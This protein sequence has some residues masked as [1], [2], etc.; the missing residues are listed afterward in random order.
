M[1]ALI[2]LL[3]LIFS[4]KILG[5]AAERIG[6][7]SIMG[8]ILAG[9]LLGLF[10]LHVETEI[11]SFFAELGSIFLLFTAGYKE[12]SL[13]DLKSEPATAFVPTFFQIAFAF[14]FGFAFG[15]IF[16]FNFLESF[17]MGVTFCPTAI[18]LVIR[19]LIDLNYLS[20]KPGMSILSSAVLDDIIGLFFLSI[21]ITFA[22][23][24]Y[25]PSFLTI[26]QIAGKILFFLLIMYILGK[27]FFPRLFV[28]AHKMHSREAVF[29]LVVM[30]A[31]FS[32]YL[33][34]LFELSAAIGAFIG[35]ISIS[36]I[37]LA[38]IQDIESKVDGLAHGILIPLF[39]AFIGFLIDFSTLRT[40]INFTFL[41]ILVALSEKLI[42][43]FVGSKAIGFNFYD[44][45]IY[46][47]GVMPKA[48]VELVMLTT[49]KE[50][51]I[52]NQEIF[53]A[54]VMMVVVSILITP[55]CLKFA[56]QAKRR[57]QRIYNRDLEANT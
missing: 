7:P 27:Y 30:I 57:N 24:K 17:F 47:I 37:P 11:I 32:A 26:F 9:A 36:E 39:F 43:G 22:H 33:A 38:K 2:Q 21:V 54:M 48:G 34:G 28:Y 12:V 18:G 23:F 20:S 10:F 8:E 3:F 41:I 4:V 46:G 56:I 55:A 50:L 1:S 45:L 52:I 19:N 31:L 49:G 16:N 5:E 14:I 53:S 15:R 35:G 6:I 29:S 44:S 40:E 42:G 51:G 13:K 25:I